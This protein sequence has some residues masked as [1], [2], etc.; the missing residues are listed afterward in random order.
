MSD[1]DAEKPRKFTRRNF[2]ALSALAGAGVA[3]EATA[4]NWENISKF[5]E[6][7]TTNED[8][9]KAQKKFDETPPDRLIHEL[10][11]GEDGARLRPFPNSAP[12]EPEAKGNFVELNPGAKLEGIEAVEVYGNNPPMPYSKERAIWYA[13]RFPNGTILFS[14]SGNFKPQPIATNKP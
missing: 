8:Q 14:Y 6:S 5:W 1:S 13:I 12:L 4:V 9:K 2:L 3:A 10:T 7:L 11:V